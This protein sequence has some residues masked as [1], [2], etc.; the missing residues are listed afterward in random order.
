MVISL[1]FLLC[2][3]LPTHHSPLPQRPCPALPAPIL[4][5][6]SWLHYCLLSDIHS[7]GC[8]SLSFQLG[9]E[10]LFLEL[11]QGVEGRLSVMISE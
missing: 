2:L 8:I 4:P 11:H 5:L 1:Y 10:I 7:E 6:H 3:S 9:H